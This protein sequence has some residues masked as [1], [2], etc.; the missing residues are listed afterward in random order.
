MSWFK[1]KP[2]VKEPPKL[3]PHH[4][5]PIAEKVLKEAKKRVSGQ[6]SSSGSNKNIGTKPGEKL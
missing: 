4:H 3:H 2:H 6:D 1:R 5:S